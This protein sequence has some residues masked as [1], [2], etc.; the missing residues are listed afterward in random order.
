[1][2][3]YA[4]TCNSRNDFTQDIY[5]STCTHAFTHTYMYSVVSSVIQASVRHFL[6]EPPSASRA[7]QPDSLQGR[8]N[9]RVATA[10]VYGLLLPDK[11]DS[12]RLKKRLAKPMAK[13][14]AKHDATDSQTQQQ[15]KHVRIVQ[16]DVAVSEGVDEVDSGKL[17]PDVAARVGSESEADR[18][19]K[20]ELSSRG[21]VSQL[22]QQFDETDSGDTPED[23]TKVAIHIA[24]VLVHVHTCVLLCGSPMLFHCVVRL[25]HY[26]QSAVSLNFH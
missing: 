21:K 11:A 16:G 18:G 17:R 20:G 22:V 24:V 8:T 7:R 14:S 15:D 12:P 26:V 25:H 9:G 19:K 5:F 13:Q 2:R 4:C 3:M 1:M 10:D 23:R 6:F